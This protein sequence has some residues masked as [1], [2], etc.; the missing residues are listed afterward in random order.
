MNKPLPQ[1]A[2][3]EISNPLPPDTSGWVRTRAVIDFYGDPIEVMDGGDL[4]GYLIN[5]LVKIDN[6]LNPD[7][8][9]KYKSSGFLI[10]RYYIPKTHLHSFG[11]YTGLVVLYNPG[12]LREIIPDPDQKPWH[13][14]ISSSSGTAR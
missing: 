1:V 7:D 8:T 5:L 4:V 3:S 10:E 6:V 13:Y 14:D 12:N 11:K 2:F 9:L